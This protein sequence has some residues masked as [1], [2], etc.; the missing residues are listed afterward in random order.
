MC[1]A[2]RRAPPLP[3][4]LRPLPWAPSHPGRPGIPPC[5]PAPRQD[6]F[7]RA[8]SSRHH[9]WLKGRTYG[10][11]SGNLIVRCE[12]PL[13]TEVFLPA[14]DGAVTRLR[15]TPEQL[16]AAAD[17]VLVEDPS[18]RWWRPVPTT[19]WRG[20]PDGYRVPGPRRVVVRRIHAALP[21]APVG[22]LAVLRALLIGMAA[23]TVA[24]AR[25]G[26]AARAWV[27]GR[28]V[29]DPRQVLATVAGTILAQT[30]INLFALSILA[31]IALSDAAITH[32]RL[33]SLA[34]ALALPAGILTVLFAGPSAL[35]RASG[36]RHHRLRRPV[37]WLSRQLDQARSGLAAFRTPATAAHATAAQLA[38]WTLQL[39]TC[40]ALMLALHLTDRANL[41][42]A[43]TVLVAVNLTAILPV[44]PS[45]V[46]IF[47]A[48]CIAA[49]TPFG[50]TASHALAYGILLQG[51]E[52]FCALM[53]GAPALVQEGAFRT[54]RH[55]SEPIS[56][57][58]SP[59]TPARPQAGSS[60]G[61]DRRD[62][63][64]PTPD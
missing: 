14:V 58:G 61:H 47:Q 3:A 16:R 27:I 1:I 45:N 28:R 10:G 22:R 26:E 17:E 24:P 19:R 50:V 2:L 51:V 21:D 59:G 36:T 34:V 38:A 63:P 15:H 40:Y 29:G 39:G 20:R 32:A 52:V 53:L 44:T 30:L 11:W 23:S 33:A 7:V 8:S 35:R 25:A 62:S 4:N 42:A 41:A 9:F 6:I 18:A 37:D 12:S 46:G 56:Q 64:Q 57:L 60:R 48:G 5:P 49:L 31:G 55:T 54:I 43:A 13:V